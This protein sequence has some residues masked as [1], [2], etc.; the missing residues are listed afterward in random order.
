MFF[1]DEPAH[2]T[3]IYS[4][5]SRG[6]PRGIIPYQIRRIK[7]DFLELH[8]LEIDTSPHELGTIITSSLASE[9]MGYSQMDYYIPIKQKD[10]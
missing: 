4:S 8:G 6:K 3:T 10:T 1:T 9:I 5:Y 2:P 7:K